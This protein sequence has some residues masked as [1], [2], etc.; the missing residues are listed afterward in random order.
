[1]FGLLVVGDQGNEQIKLVLNE[2]DLE[3]PSGNYQAASE[4][5]VLVPGAEF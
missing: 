3:M 1:M 5:I 2:I 4:F